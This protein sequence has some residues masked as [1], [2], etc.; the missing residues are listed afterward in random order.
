MSKKATSKKAKK[1][2][3]V[4]PLADSKL[5]KALEEGHRP[6][7]KPGLQA[8]ESNHKS[9]LRI[10]EGR[11]VASI[12]VD[13]AMKEAE[14][15]SNRW[16]YLVEYLNKVFAIEVHPC[17]EGEAKLIEKKAEWIRAWISKQ[18]SLKKVVHTPKLAVCY[19]ISSGKTAL[20]QLAPKAKALATKKIIICGSI[21]D[22]NKYVD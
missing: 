12:D 7:C 19:W 11:F 21:W 6:Q 18:P 5:F 20:S 9:Q 16:D 14:P 8:L 17:T 2:E 4:D 3:P 22:F 13:K 1:R 10:P 15:N